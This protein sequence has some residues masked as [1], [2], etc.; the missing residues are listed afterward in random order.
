MTLNSEALEVAASAVEDHGRD[1]GIEEWPAVAGAFAVEAITAYLAALPTGDM[2]PFPTHR[3]D[4]AKEV[5]SRTSNSSAPATEVPPQGETSKAKDCPF[6]WTG[7]PCPTPDHCRALASHTQGEG[8][9]Q[10]GERELAANWLKKH[11]ADMRR[12]GRP[13]DVLWSERLLVALTQSPTLEPTDA[14][15]ERAARAMAALEDQPVNALWR[16]HARAALIAS[17]QSGEGV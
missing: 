5:P 12:L 4:G 15:V 17:R 14:E 9:W 1:C 10:N 11:A 16:I 6:C 3:F 13:D 7:A 8:A 2:S